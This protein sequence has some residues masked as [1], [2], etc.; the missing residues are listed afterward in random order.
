MIISPGKRIIMMY[1]I[2]MMQIALVFIPL[3]QEL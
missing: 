1:S 3:F 2:V